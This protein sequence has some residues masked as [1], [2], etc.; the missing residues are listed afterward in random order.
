MREKVFEWAEAFCGVRPDYPFDSS[1]DAAVLRKASGKWFAIAME[2]PKNKLG[3]SGDGMVDII[4][5]KRDPM[6]NLAD[7]AR[8]FPAYHMN[9]EHWI[10]VLL[11]GSVSLEELAALLSMSYDL[12]K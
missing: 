8:I 10:S 2:V 1:P 7:G 9:K 5:L 4:N 12:I 3:L 6:L 11:D